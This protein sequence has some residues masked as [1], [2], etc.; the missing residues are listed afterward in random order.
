MEAAKTSETLVNF[1]QTAR[2]YNPEDSH[3]RTHRRE[4]LKSYFP[5]NTKN[6]RLINRNC[7][8][9]KRNPRKRHT[10]IFHGPTFG[11]GCMKPTHHGL[12]RSR[13]CPCKRNKMFPRHIPSSNQPTLSNTLF[14]LCL[15]ILSQDCQRG[16]FRCDFC[17]NCCLEFS[18]SRKAFSLIYLAELWLLLL[19]LLLFHILLFTN[20][21][22]LW[23]WDVRSAIQ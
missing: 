23:A 15:W 12:H 14:S 19:L 6:L 20:Q 11:I 21:L 3:L 2:R 4:N 22:D 16:A 17:F 8:W 13:N 5:Q 1:Y 7:S 18:I 9:G 10:C